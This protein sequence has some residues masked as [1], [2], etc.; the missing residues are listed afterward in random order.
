MLRFPPISQCA[1]LA[2]SIGAYICVS[3]ANASSCEFNAC[4]IVSPQTGNTRVC[5]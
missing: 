5:A 3:H 4:F 2:M 1:E